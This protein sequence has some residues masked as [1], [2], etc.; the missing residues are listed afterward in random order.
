MM[1]LYEILDGFAAYEGLEDMILIFLIIF[2][3]ISILILVFYLLGVIGKWRVFSKAGIAG[4]KSVIPVYNTYLFC[5]ICGLNTMWVWIILGSAIVS[6]VVP[7]LAAIYS[8]VTIY[9]LILQTVSLSKSFG[10]S[11]AFAI[12]LIFAA[13][14]FYLILGCGKS[15]YQGAIPMQDFVLELLGINEK[16]V[17]VE[18]TKAAVKQDVVTE[19]KSVE[20]VSNSV[21]NNFEKKFCSSCGAGLEEGA[22]FC[23]HC[24]HKI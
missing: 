11:D 20:N 5:Q 9:F 17:S 2:S 15:T 18:S 22:S 19:S 12:G 24:G 8:L 13:P 1:A 3:V 16:K 21:S 23:A 10:K 4:W 14:I 6:V 7:P